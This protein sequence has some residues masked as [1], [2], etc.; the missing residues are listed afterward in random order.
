MITFLVQYRRSKFETV[1]PTDN[2]KER[3]SSKIF[4]D[5][6]KGE[7]IKKENHYSA[8]TVTITY[9]KQVQKRLLLRTFSYAL[10]K[11]KCKHTHTDNTKQ[12]NNLIVQISTNP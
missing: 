4:E 5:D 1:N 6:T 3:N 2:V 8:N 11:A 12:T 9:T 7:K 10:L